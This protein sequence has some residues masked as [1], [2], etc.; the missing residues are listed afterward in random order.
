MRERREALAALR[1]RVARLP[2]AAGP[3]RF[4][5]ALAR[6][7]RLNVIA[8]CKRRSPSR[9]V[10]RA[11]YDPGAIARGYAEAGAAAISVL[12][13]PTFF[14]GSLD[15]LAAVRAAVTIPVLRKDFI[16]SEY[17]LLEARAAGADAV[18]L[19]VAALEPRELR[20]LAECAAGLGL[21]VLVEVHDADELAMAID[22]GARVVG[23]NNR[24]LRTLEV[25]VKASET[26]IGLMPKGVVAVSESGLK[27]SEDLARLRQQGYQAFLIG[28]RLMTRAGSGTGAAR[29]A[30]GRAVLVKICGITRRE[31]AEAAV[32]AGA[33]AIGFVFWPK[34]PRAIDPYRARAIAAAL[35][36][37][38]TTV[39][40]FV[41]QPAEYV[42]GVAGLAR[43]GAVQLHGEEPPDYVAAMTRPVVKAVA[44]RNGLEPA[45][46]A[47]EQWPSRVVVL[48]DVH[49]PERRGGTGRTVDWSVAAAIARRRP[50]VLAGGLTAEN[51]SEA[52]ARV[53]P[54]GIDVSSGVEAAPGIKDHGRIKALFEAVHGSGITTRP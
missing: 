19:I 27:T 26:L 4:A 45:A 43:L 16:V 7:D 50:V 47:L 52:I 23:V 9:G 48:L 49:D 11:D 34:S 28:E 17:Q 12:T 21:D 38:V 54:F 6:R 20:S 14:D 42:N 39:G 35:P 5:G 13:E 31:D 3:G 41:D 8:E 18:L 32:S 24:N 40:V 44:L 30:G 22:A 36:P 15:H 10:L 1:D 37:F 33:D 29:T 2:G 46:I 51:V 53:R 25:D